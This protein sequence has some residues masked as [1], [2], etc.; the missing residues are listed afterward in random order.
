MSGQAFHPD[1]RSGLDEIWDYI[2]ADNLD[3]ADQV[4]TEILAAIRAVVPFRNR[5]SLS[6]IVAL[7]HGAQIK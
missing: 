3:A 4:I 2:G 6:K 7:K 1:A 5:K